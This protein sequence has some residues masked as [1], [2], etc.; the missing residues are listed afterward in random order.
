ME[1]D[2]ARLGPGATELLWSF[3]QVLVGA[4]GVLYWL[5]TV[6]E[7]ARGVPAPRPAHPSPR[8][9]FKQPL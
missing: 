3:Q 8:S 2:D 4:K 6:R 7:I 1:E 9:A 5:V